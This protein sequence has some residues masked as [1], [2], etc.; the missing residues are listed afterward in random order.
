MKRS[1]QEAIMAYFKVL[2]KHLPVGTEEI[3][4]KAVRTAGFCLHFELDTSCT[5]GR[6]FITKIACSMNKCLYDILLF[7]VSL[8]ML[9]QI[10]G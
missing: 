8:M 1:G 10:T 5:Q 6:C 2:S 3:P 7:L 9:C 4:R